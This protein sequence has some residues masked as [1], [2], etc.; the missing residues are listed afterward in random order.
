MVPQVLL[1]RKANAPK[2]L[3]VI[4]DYRTGVLEVMEVPAPVVRPGKLLIRTAASAVSAGTERHLVEMA[5][6]SLLGKALA[7]P[8][9]VRRVLDKV[10]TDG[11]RETIQQVRQRLDTS[12]PLGYSAAGIVV[13]V[14]EGVTGFR[15]GDLVVCGGQGV[16]VHAE[17]LCAPPTLVIPVPSGVKI[18]HAAFAMVGAIPLH[19]ARLS[20]VQ[21]GE[22][23]GVIGLGLLGLLAVQLLKAAGCRVVG[24]DVVPGKLGLAK[25]LGA[26]ATVNS[27]SPDAAVQASL[28]TAGRGVDAAVITASTSGNGPIELAAQICRERGRVVAAGLVGLEVPRHDFFERELELVVSRASGAGLYDP[29]YE[30][31]GVEYPYAHVRWTHSRN[32]AE[33]LRLVATGAV[34]LDPLITHRFPVSDAHQAYRVL[35][36]ET[37]EAPIGILLQYPAQP[38]AAS[39]VVPVR[40][41][42]RSRPARPAIRVGLI[43]AGL[44][45]KTTLLP[46]MR[47]VREVHLMGV[48]TSS[49]AGADHVARTFGFE[50]ATTDPEEILRN[51]DIDC[52]FIATRHDSHARLVIAALQRG[53]DVFVEKPLALTRAELQGIADAWSAGEA[54]L[55]VGFNR[56]HSPHALAARSFLADG[57]GPILLRCRVNAGDVPV[58]SW[59]N[60]PLR[61]GDRIRGELCHF[62]DLAHFLLDERP[63]AAEAVA[64][65]PARL[66][67]PIEDVVAVLEFAGGSVASL[68]YTAL[69]H[70]RLPRE[71]IEAFRGGRVAVIDNF[72]IT[73]F[74]GLRPPR[75]C[76]TWRLDRGYRG[77]LSV[78][79]QALAEGKPAPVPFSDYVTSTLAT[80]AVADAVS[81]GQRVSLD[82]GAVSIGARGV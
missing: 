44:F 27:N 69:G 26:E 12:V 81:T 6:K 56:R 68:T 20:R 42:A 14:G 82:P 4:Q 58:G 36:G 40:G 64:L 17:V 80:L 39:R 18:E 79:F 61:G 51:P 53:K 23:V 29:A 73:R 38:C 78:W 74:Y 16:A 54:R 48:A 34:Q 22:W 21:A 52:V 47:R 15:V 32:M 35:K 7:R 24:F 10:R 57:A 37:G 76:R 71:H 41:S 62:V 63:A 13:A 66:D 33:F 8:D 43:G 75:S 5:R 67:A 2:M 45:A 25:A 1:R 19:A 60:D 77:E 70:R 55:M 65:R 59:V 31:H 11:L 9:L 46:E 72:R 28:L 49:G 50:Y 3:Q 30:V